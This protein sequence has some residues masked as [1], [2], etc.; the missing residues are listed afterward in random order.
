MNIG[1]HKLKHGLSLPAIAG[2]SDIGLRMLC[3]RF[4]A[5]L[6]CTEMISAKGLIYENE[7]TKAL[8]A[9]HPTEDLVAVQ[10]F[11]SDP[12]IIARAIS[13]DILSRFDIID[14]NFGCPARKIVQNGDGCAVMRDL[15]LLYA[16]VSSA[17]KAANTRPVTVKLRSGL[18]QNSVN[19]PDAAKV[20]EDAGAQAITIHGRTADTGYSGKCSLDIV[21]SV[22]QSVSI[23][24]IGNGDVVDQ[25]SYQHMLKECNVDGVAIARA[26]LG[27]PFI[28]SEVRGVATPTKEEAFN[29]VIEHFDENLKV[30]PEHTVVREMK[31]QAVLY[32]KLIRGGKNFHQAIFSASTADQ[33]KEVLFYAKEKASICNFNAI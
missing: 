15:K 17:V 26:A 19:A 24:V 1:K 25:K 4:G 29:L 7:K 23:P 12:N 13:L 14:L 11:G 20:A 30:F 3:K 9:V 32:L 6:T 22:K 28:F 31:K 16:I 33:F 21:A 18:S 27:R 10:L 8:L 2:F 5:D